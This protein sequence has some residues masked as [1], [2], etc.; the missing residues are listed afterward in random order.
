MSY[1]AGVFFFW[2]AVYIDLIA[3]LTTL[4]LWWACHRLIAS[5]LPAV[6]GR[7]VTFAVEGNSYNDFLFQ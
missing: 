2:Q 1:L 4:D 3:L 7:V 5:W 6:P